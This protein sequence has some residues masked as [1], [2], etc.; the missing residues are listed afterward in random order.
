[1]P[2]DHPPAA[3]VMGQPLGGVNGHGKMSLLYD[4]RVVTS[5]GRR[6][7]PWGRPVRSPDRAKKGDL[8]YAPLHSRMLYRNYVVQQISKKYS[9]KPEAQL[10]ITHSLYAK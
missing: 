5:G 10:R 6:G 7:V 4:I 8:H 9:V 1:M 2:Q 3:T